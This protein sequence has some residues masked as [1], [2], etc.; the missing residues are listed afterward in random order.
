MRQNDGLRWGWS[1]PAGHC[2]VC[3]KLVSVCNRRQ[4]EG[5][6]HE[7]RHLTKDE[8]DWCGLTDSVENLDRFNDPFF[9]EVHGLMDKRLTRL[10]NEIESLWTTFCCQVETF[11]A[12]H[13]NVV[14]VTGNEDWRKERKKRLTGYGSWMQVAADVVGGSCW[15]R[16]SKAG[17][18]HWQTVEGEMGWVMSDQLTSHICNPHLNVLY[19]AWLALEAICLAWVQAIQCDCLSLTWIDIFMFTLHISWVLLED[20]W[21]NL[22]TLVL[23]KRSSATIY[24]TCK[25]SPVRFECMSSQCSRDI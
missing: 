7:V 18:K 21:V 12:L 11:L 14:H 2:L 6:E 24:P 3:K 19:C 8:M 1:K 17:Y 25:A 15:Q 10:N 16:E 4:G 5:Y 20:N 13:S 22:G 23:S 9:I